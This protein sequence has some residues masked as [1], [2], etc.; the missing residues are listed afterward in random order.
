MRDDRSR[1]FDGRGVL[2]PVPVSVAALLSYLLLG[3]Y[4]V[5][6]F[7]CIV[8]AMNPMTAVTVTPIA[9]C[10][11]VFVFFT[12]C[13]WSVYPFQSLVRARRRRRWLCPSC[14][15]PLCDMLQEADGCTVCPECG[16]AW[17][18]PEASSA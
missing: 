10:T 15:F 9:A 13:V 12:G 6:L 16:A 1:Q 8:Y 4:V 18:L 11:L 17:R 3:A 14:R 5:A 7:A 2:R